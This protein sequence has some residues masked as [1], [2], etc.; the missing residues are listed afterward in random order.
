MTPSRRTVI[1]C[2]SVTHCSAMP[3][4]ISSPVTLFK[5]GQQIIPFDVFK[6]EWGVTEHFRRQNV[7]ICSKVFSCDSL[8]HC[9]KR[10]PDLR[11]FMLF[12]SPAMLIIVLCTANGEREEKVSPFFLNGLLKIWVHKVFCC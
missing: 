1:L 10:S 11:F 6:D 2:K 5:V 9:T 7:F 4:L 3:S 12:G 8:A